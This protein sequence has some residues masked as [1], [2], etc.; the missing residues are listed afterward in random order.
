ME[1]APEVVKQLT[2]LVGKDPT[3]GRGRLVK[4]TG[5]TRRQVERFLRTRTSQTPSPGQAS[6]Q[7]LP[8]KEFV[9]RYDYA[10]MMRS[11]I[12]RLCRKA[13]LPDSAM[14]VESGIPIGAYRAVADLPEFRQCQIKSHD[15]TWW[16]TSAN[17]EKVRK[18]TQKWGIRR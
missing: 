8:L 5:L 14:R 16:S 4:M 6:P 9:G 17:A 12:Q 10:G 15:G 11:A 7:A 13:F 3:L 1:L 2:Q 18:E